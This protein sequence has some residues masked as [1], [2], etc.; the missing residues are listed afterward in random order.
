M[1]TP[2]ALP[3]EIHCLLPRST[4][5]SGVA[6]G[7]RLHPGRIAPGVGLAQRE[8]PEPLA[9]LRQ[10]RAVV[11]LLRR[12][13]EPHD[14]LAHHVGDAHRH[15]GRRARARHFLDR[16]R[17][18]DCSGARPAELR[19]DVHRHQ[20]QVTETVHDL[21]RYRLGGVDRR[22][23][24]HDDALGEVPRGLLDEGL[25]VAGREVHLSA[26]PLRDRSRPSPA[27]CRATAAPSS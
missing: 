7:R 6:A 5:P 27:S 13:P 3:P 14:R 8:A 16:E 10:E 12:G 19:R 9:A 17:V 1:K 2:A 23:A 18:R 15:R 11:G 25:R 4:H 20:A 26:P 22:R 24:R 21:V